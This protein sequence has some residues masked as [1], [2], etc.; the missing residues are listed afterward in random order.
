MIA[1]NL[2][3]HLN[4]FL[5]T[6][7]NPLQLTLM[8]W[9]KIWEFP[10]LSRTFLA[11]FQSKLRIYQYSALI[12]VIKMFRKLKSL[13]KLQIHR[14]R[15]RS[16]RQYI[17]MPTTQDGARLCWMELPHRLLPVPHPLNH[18]YSKKQIPFR[19]SAS[20]R[21]SSKISFLR[22]TPNPSPLS[23]KLRRNVFLS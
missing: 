4:T 1:E 17:R 16:H 6:C 11:I 19:K 12:F 5:R 21:N 8:L 18:Q 10:I 20:I 23:R 15:R 13:I 14:R 9:I 7:Q 22:Q 2:R 3:E